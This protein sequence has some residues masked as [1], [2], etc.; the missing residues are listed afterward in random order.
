MSLGLDPWITW[1]GTAVYQPDWG[2]DSRSLAFTLGSVDGDASFHVILNAYW[3]ALPFEL[4]TPPHRSIWLRVVDTSLDPPDDL[5]TPGR[6]V[7][8]TRGCYPAGP[9]SAVVLMSS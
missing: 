1:H 4:P 7:A 5:A 9:R 6:E 8:V 2:H 3:E